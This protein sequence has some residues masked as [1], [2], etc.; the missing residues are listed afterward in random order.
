MNYYTTLILGYGEH[1][2]DEFAK[3]LAAQLRL[4][5]CSSSEFACKRVVYPWFGRVFP[6]YYK[7]QKHCFEDR[8]NWRACWHTLIAR[9]NTPDKTK[10]A[11]EV[12]Q[13]HDIYVGMRC[14]LELKAVVEKGVFRYIFWVDATKRK[15]IENTASNSIHFNPTIMRRIDNNQD[16]P[17]LDMQAKRI[18]NGIR[19]VGRDYHHDKVD[20]SYYQK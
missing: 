15:P 6:G 7:D 19:R 14:K 9:Y 3:M 13:H 1:G 5:L 16:I 12:L 8:R 2:K 20:L 11:T 18:A 17:H 4:R 10:L